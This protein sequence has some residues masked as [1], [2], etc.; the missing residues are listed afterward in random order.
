MLYNDMK[1]DDVDIVLGY[2]CAC[3]KGMNVDAS[4][5]IGYDDGGKGKVIRAVA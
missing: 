1:L 2:A 4:Y 3:A 5:K